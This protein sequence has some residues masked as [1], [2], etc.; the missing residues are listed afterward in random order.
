MRDGSVVGAVER[1][2]FDETL[3][4]RMMVGREIVLRVPHVSVALGDPVLEVEDATVEGPARPLL[5]HISFSVR[6]GEIFAVAGVDGNGQSE[7]FDVLVGLRE[8]TSGSVRICGEV[9][10]RFSPREFARRSGGAVPE[11]RHASGLALDLTVADNLV[12]A[13]L[14]HGRFVR[15]GMLD[16]NAIARHCRGLLEAYDVDVGTLHNSIRHLSG[17]N[18]QRVVLARAL[19]DRPRLLVAS[20]PTRGLDVGAIEFVYRHLLDLKKAGSGIVLISGELEEVLS[21]AD[22][23]AVLVQGRFAGVLD[24]ERADQETLG[25]LMSGARWESAA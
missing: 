9:V 18:Q 23:I 10:P 5:D 15:R 16:G 14:S 6:G 24:R 19:H 25:L 4:A 20:Q 1:G 17:G 13:D 7:L 12:L 21:L 8:P 11:D 2:S 3:L 22:R